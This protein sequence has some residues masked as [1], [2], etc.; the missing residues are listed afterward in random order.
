MTQLKAA[1]KELQDQG[2]IIPDYPEEAKTEEQKQIKNR[3]SKVLGSAVNPVLREGT[4]ID[5]LQSQLKSLP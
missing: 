1:I 2:Y 5:E 4:L 3:Y